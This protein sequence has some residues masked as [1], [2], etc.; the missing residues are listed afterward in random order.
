MHIFRYLRKGFSLRLVNFAGLTVFL[1]SLLLSIG[2]ITH[3]RSYDRHHS[4]ADR[5][6]RFSLRI[7]GEEMGDVRIPGKNVQEVL[8]TVPEIEKVARIY[9]ANNSD[10]AFHGKHFS[11]TGDMF[12]VNREFFEVFDVPLNA[13]EDGGMVGQTFVSR[14]YAAHL[15]AETGVEDVLGKRIKFWD[16]G[17][18]AGTFYDFP[19]TSHFKADILKFWAE[20]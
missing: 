7:D 1:V 9:N 8:M 18:I 4:K 17:Y 2:Y 3:E 5:I 11:N 15:A 14:N 13:Y 12:I 20:F 10:V 16:D 19:E 6:V